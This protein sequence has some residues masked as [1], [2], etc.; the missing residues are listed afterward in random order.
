MEVE[1]IILSGIH[2]W[3][4]S[5]QIWTELHEKYLVPAAD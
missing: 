4:L 1:K 5:R 2:V 3:I